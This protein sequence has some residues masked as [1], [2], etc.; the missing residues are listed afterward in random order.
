MQRF[1]IGSGRVNRVTWCFM[2]ALMFML[3][4]S[5]TLAHAQEKKAAASTIDEKAM[6]TLM[7]MAEFLAKAQQFSVT[8]DIGYEVEQDWGQ[9]L[10]FGAT[11]AITVR[12]PDR[13][14][15][16]ITDRDGTRRGFRF[17]GKQI[18]FFGLDEKAYAT[19]QKSG[20]LDA[21]IAYFKQDLHM[22][23]PLAELVSNNL[24]KILKERTD[25]AYAVEEATIGGTRCDHLALRNE[26]VDAQIW[27]AK[28][29]QPLPQRIVITYKQEDG[30]PDFWAN[31]RG[32]NLSLET[33]DSLF[34]FTPVD[35]MDRIPFV[36]GM[37]PDA[38]MK[39]QGAQP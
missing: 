26:L 5:N 6:A 32:W 4:L 17:D 34:T 19:A 30:K 7:Q 13:L 2:S 21:A 29:D 33:P 14:A 35:G 16:D 20:D 9:K 10:E 39:E 11:R 28:G 31:F 8:T 27:I 24:P 37:D 23:L 1:S 36:A 3:M 18:A 12:R 15:V 38:G 22:P 25:E